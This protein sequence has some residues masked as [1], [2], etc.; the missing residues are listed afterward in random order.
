MINIKRALNDDRLMKAM[1]G[2]SASEFNRLIGRF[3][4]EIQNELWNKYQIG[5]EKRNRERKPGGGRIGSLKSDKWKLF[6]LLFYFKCYPTFDILGLIFDLNR[7]NSNR[8]VHKLTLALERAL[9]REM[10]LPKRK[11]RTMEELFEAF[12]E[13]KEIII[14][15][16]ERLIQRPKDVEKQKKN[17]SGK[18][19]AHTCKNIVISDE[20]RRIGYLSPTAEG[21]K[22]DYRIFKEEFP[23]PS[24]IFPENVTLWMDLGFIGVEKDYPCATVMMPAKKPRGKELT[25]EAKKR[26]K[27]INGF[28]VVVEHAI[29]GVKRFGVVADKFRNRKCGFGDKVMLISCGLWNYH[30]L[31]R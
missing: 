15:G 11:I 19:K 2:L 8:N 18:K 16:T 7:S 6:F 20:N 28:R 13:V 23:P 1:T 5:V 22:H 21:K 25:D 12:P 29:G 14:D 10:T 27:A 4:Q 17:Y 24:D 3:S 30:L 31:C 9:G 26:N